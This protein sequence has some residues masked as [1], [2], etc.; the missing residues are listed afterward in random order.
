[1]THRDTLFTM[2]ALMCLWPTAGRTCAD[3]P[4]AEL[5]KRPRLVAQLGHS[6]LIVAIS[7]SGDGKWLVTSSGDKTV[8]LWDAATLLF[9]PS[10]D[11]R[12]RQQKQGST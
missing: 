11:H 12:P 6:G 5:D 8:R 4:K 2:A 9:T 10:S 1:M 3:D 7:W